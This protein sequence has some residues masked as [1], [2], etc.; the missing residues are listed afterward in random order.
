[1]VK[2]KKTALTLE[3]LSMRMERGFAGVSENIDKLAELMMGEFHRV[4]ERFVGVDKRLDAMDVRFDAI[5]ARFDRLEEEVRAIRHDIANILDR[6]D[7]LEEQVGSIRGYS[8]E[9][10]ELRS[11]VNILEA[12]LKKLTRAHA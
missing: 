8:K 4:D 11:R 9:I 10:D 2:A 12:Q 5:D 1:M 6:L 7:V 3:Q